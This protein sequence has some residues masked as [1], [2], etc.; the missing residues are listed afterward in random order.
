M[1]L[2]IQNL[3]KH[4]WMA[5]GEKKKP[6]KK[7][8]ITMKTTE[9]FPKDRQVL[10]VKTKPRGDK[11]FVSLFHHVN[12]LIDSNISLFVFNLLSIHLNLITKQTFLWVAGFAE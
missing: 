5:K 3:K 1:R 4:E 2:F 8:V 9:D 12:P 10:H 6:Y 11:Y 7:N